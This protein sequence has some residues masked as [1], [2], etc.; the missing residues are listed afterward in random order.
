M[1][2]LEAQV[3]VEATGNYDE[4]D[5]DYIMEAY[6]ELMKNLGFEDKRRDN[7]YVVKFHD[8]Y[9]YTP[10]EY[11]D[12]H[13]DTYDVLFEDFCNMQYDYIMEDATENNIDMDIMLSH[14]CVGHYETF[15]VDI[16]NITDENAIQLA[17]DI[18]DE[19]GYRAAEYVKG[20]IYLVNVLQDLEDNYM[21]YWIQHIEDNELMPKK[22][23]KQ[24]KTKY[25]KDKERRK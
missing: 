17:M 7:R 25:N 22:Y 9:Y 18:Y 5:V 6:E 16:K 2:K 20:Y 4:I 15:R 8:I 24:M 1:N 13:G 11:M 23:I 14:M 12:K 21:E 19:V 10:D 3:I